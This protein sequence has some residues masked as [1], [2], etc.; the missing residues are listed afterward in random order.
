MSSA[1]LT[2]ILRSA[3]FRLPLLYAVLFT[4]FGW[5]EPRGAWAEWADGRLHLCV[6]GQGVWTQKTELARM[7]RL[8]ADAV[9]VTTPA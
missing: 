4:A 3:S 5:F 9:R 8:S 6:N 7:L 2:R 1:R